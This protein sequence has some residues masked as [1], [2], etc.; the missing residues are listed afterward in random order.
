[1]ND[2]PKNQRIEIRLSKSDKKLIERMAK[3]MKISNSELIRYAINSVNQRESFEVDVSPL[4]ATAYEM[5]KQGT[6]LNQL[7]YYFNSHSRECTRE[8][9]EDVRFTL[10]KHR[11]LC[12]QIDKVYMDFKAANDKH[13]VIL[14]NNDIDISDAYKDSAEPIESSDKRPY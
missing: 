11:K 6:N 2:E 9:I 8:M 10:A 5:R 4:R 12:E 14:H 13:E 7:L 3:K 1:M